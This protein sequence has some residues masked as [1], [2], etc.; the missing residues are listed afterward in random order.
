MRTE[1]ILPVVAG[2][3]LIFLASCS[4]EPIKLGPRPDIAGI[5]VQNQE[6]IKQTRSTRD[7]VKKFSDS[8]RTVRQKA[9]ETETALETAKKYLT[10]L[11]TEG[12]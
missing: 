1:Q 7:N 3:T 10:E 6:T 8:N 9:V 11:L 4:T 12:E 2:L 5:R